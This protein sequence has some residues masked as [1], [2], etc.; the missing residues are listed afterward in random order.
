MDCSPVDGNCAAKPTARLQHVCE[1][2]RVP[3]CRRSEVFP[4]NSAIAAATVKPVPTP[5]DGTT[6]LQTILRTAAAMLIVIAI[7]DTG[8]STSNPWQRPAAA[9]A[10]AD[11][12]VTVARAELGRALFFDPRLSAKGSMSCASCHNPATT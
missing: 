8:A 9:P 7:A 1:E 3:A 10:P 5:A 4:E 12:H 11:N 6:M 2:T